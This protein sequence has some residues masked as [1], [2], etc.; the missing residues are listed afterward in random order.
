GS[1]WAMGHGTSGQLGDGTV[2]Y[3]RNTPEMIV[4]SGVAAISAG[5]T[6]SMFLK[7]DGTL[8]VMG[9]GTYGALGDGSV[10]QQVLSPEMITNHVVAICA[11]FD[12]ALFIRN[13]GT[14]WDM[15]SD[16]HGELGDGTN[17][18]T[19]RP[20]NPF[21]DTDIIGLAGGESFSLFL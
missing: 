4:S 5:N 8:W 12:H 6:Y 20:L 14:L 16:Q 11:A 18:N 7:T 2:D 9:Q 1:L 15:G 19:S 21:P 3:Y 13:D 10:A 17:N